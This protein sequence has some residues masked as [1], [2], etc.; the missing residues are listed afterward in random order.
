M[1]VNLPEL[2]LN[3][4]QLSDEELDQLARAADCEL[5]ERL[6][7]QQEIAALETLGLTPVYRCPDP[8]HQRWGLYAEDLHKSGHLVCGCPVSRAELAG[9]E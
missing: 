2:L 3:L 9:Y 4:K 7:R 6:Y 1:N 5:Q 8:E